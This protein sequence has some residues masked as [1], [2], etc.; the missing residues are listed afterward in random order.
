MS[1][2]S[3]IKFLLE[4][5]GDMSTAGE[6][7]KDVIDKAARSQ[8]PVER[9]KAARLTRIK[10]LQDQNKRNQDDIPKCCT[11]LFLLSATN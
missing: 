10:Q 5:D 6:V 2:L 1:K 8:D 3:F 7:T 9:Q 11:R 4:V